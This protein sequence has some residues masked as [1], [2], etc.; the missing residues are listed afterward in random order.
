MKD[1]LSIKEIAEYYKVNQNIVFHNLDRYKIKIYPWLYH[2][3][4]KVRL[5]PKIKI[6][7]D[8]WLEF[9]GYWISEGHVTYNT[10]TS[11]IGIAQQYI[12]YNPFNKDSWPKMNKCFKKL[13]QLIGVNLGNQKLGHF[14]FNSIQIGNY[15]S[16][17]GKAKTYSKF[18]PKELKNLSKRQLKILFDALMLGDGCKTGKNKGKFFSTSSPKLKDDFQELCLKLGYVATAKKT[19]L[20]IATKKLSKPHFNTNGIKNDKWIDYQGKIYCVTVPNHIIYTRRDG[21]GIW[22]GNSVFEIKDGKAIQIH[23]KMMKGWKYY[24]GKKFDPFHP[25]QVE[26]CREAIKQF[27]IGFLY[28]DNTR[29]EFEGASDSGLLTTHFVPIVFT[30]KT[31]VQMATDF[32]K[33]VLNKQIE[34]FDDEEILDSLCSVTNDYQK[35]ESIGG[36]A[37][38]FDSFCLALIGYS[39][40]G[41][42]G[43][44]K[45]IRAGSQNV[46]SGKLPK[47]W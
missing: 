45:E 35:I 10:E 8:I 46:F 25:T 24:S 14:F 33:I 9:L 12:R 32:E 28:Y 36:H 29:G 19:R 42:S 37:D 5:Y 13:T 2:R 27:G 23:H 4:N 11:Q 7:M 3:K 6:P 44:N 43:N 20:I 40:F 15:L 21:K 31:K 1:K 41:A 47:G 22:S 16:M 26:Y 17:L 38:C 30:A 39:K 18:I 34:M